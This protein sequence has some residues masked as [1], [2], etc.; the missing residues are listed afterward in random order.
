MK[1]FIFILLIFCSFSTLVYSQDFPSLDR[2]PMD[3]AYLPDNFAHDR[4]EGE[5][6][7]V[8]VY[9]SRPAKNGREVFGKMAAF[10]KVWRLGAN[11]AVEF[12][13]YQDVTLGGKNIKAGA[14]SMFAIPGE[15]EWTIILNSDLD[16]WGAYSYQ[17]KNDVVRFTVPAKSLPEVVEAFSIRFEDLG[18]NAAVMR[19]AWDQTMVEIPLKY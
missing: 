3:V 2:S 14:Y 15:A 9:Y 1:H 13:T 8:K 12:K 10:D 4:M 16:Y 18:N 11:E 6:A 19:I 17:E 5:K 7:I